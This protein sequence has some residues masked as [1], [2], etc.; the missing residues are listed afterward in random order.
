MKIIVF[1]DIHGAVRPFSRIPE[2]IS[3]ADVVVLAGDITNFGREKDA[4]QVIDAIRTQNRNILAVPGNCDYPEVEK[5]LTNV[6]MNLDCDGAIL[7]DVAFIGVGGSLPCPGRT[8][9]EYSEEALRTC[10]DSGFAQLGTIHPFILIAHQ[11]PHDTVADGI[12][13]W[14]V[15]SNAIRAFIE[16]HQPIV[17]VTGHIHEGKGVDN[18]GGTKVVNPGPFSKGNYAII[19]IID[20]NVEIEIRNVR[21]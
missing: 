16:K 10:A 9:N 5:Y 4:R 17:C 11:P 2:E 3:V 18:I 21:D 7:K 15:G 8:P 14:H 6:G 20:R 13:D 12:K 1:A 19:D